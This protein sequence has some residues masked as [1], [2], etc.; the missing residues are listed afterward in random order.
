MRCLRIA[1][2]SCCPG[3]LVDQVSRSFSMGNQFFVRRPLPQRA[4]LHLGDGP[5]V[6]QCAPGGLFAP[7]VK[8]TWNPTTSPH[9]SQERGVEHFWGRSTQT[10]CGPPFLGTTVQSPISAG[11]RAARRGRRESLPN[12]TEVPDPG[13]VIARRNC[14]TPSPSDWRGIIVEPPTQLLVNP[15][16]PSTSETGRT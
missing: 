10:S 1:A 11:S 7:S 15:F 9:R 2:V 6:S 14:T 4:E 16:A 3:C 5:R 13:G 12:V 8:G